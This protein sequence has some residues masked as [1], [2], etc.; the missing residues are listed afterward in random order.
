M[1]WVSCAHHVL[2]IPHLLCQLRYCQGTILLRAAGSEGGEADHKKMKTGEGDQ[3]C[4]KLAEV[5][6]EL[7]RKA[8][9]ARHTYSE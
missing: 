1:T 6:I 2:C 4:G 9:A 5:S 7:T 3:V 8:Q